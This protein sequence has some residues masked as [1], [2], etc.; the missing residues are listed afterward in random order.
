METAPNQAS[1]Q[2]TESTLQLNRSLL[3]IDEYAASKGLSRGIIEEYG[4]Q[5]LVQIRRHSGKI[6][7][8]DVPISPYRSPPEGSDGAINTGANNQLLKKISE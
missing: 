2:G 7:V 6:F 3:P 5:G 8:V 4:R 1:A